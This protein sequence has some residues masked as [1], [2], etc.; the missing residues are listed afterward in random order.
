M[1]GTTKPTPTQKSTNSTPV[2]GNAKNTASISSKTKKGY[3]KKA[4]ELIKKLQESAEKLGEA[5]VEWEKEGAE[6][7]SMAKSRLMQLEPFFAMLLFKL[8]AYPCYAIPTVSTDGSVILYNPQF[9]H[10]HMLRKDVLFTLLHEIEHVFLKHNTRGPIKGVDA[11][12]IMKRY[13]KSKESGVKD[14]FMDDHIEEMKHVL[15]EWNKAADY[16]INDHIFN[17]TN[18]QPTKKFK[19]KLLYNKQYTDKTSEY[20]YK[21]IKTKRDPKKQEEFDV[22]IGGILPVGFGGED[23]S[24][25]EVAAFE[26]EFEGE[27]KAAALSARRAGKLP[28]GIE[29]TIEDLYTTTTPWQDIFR[30]IFTS[31][32]K[33]DYTFAYPNKRY[34]QHMLD[35]GVI[36]PSLYGEEY[37]NCG[38]IMDTSGSVGPREKAILV[39]ELK[40]I[41]EDYPIKLHVL[42]CDSKAYTND[43][44][45]LTQADI[46]A[47]K[48]KLNVK[49]GGGTDMRPAFDY[50]R[51]NQDELQFETVICLTDMYLFNW[52]LGSEPPFST[53]WARL[54]QADKNVKPPFGSCIDIEVDGGDYNDYD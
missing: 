38:F 32:N 20:V 25:A 24:E 51:D 31:I 54:P 49:G 2:K 6:K 5:K 11:K 39:S 8:P 45:I 46:K 41:L 26:K 21:K 33:Q 12:A 48:L 27:V 13:L 23:M 1:S 35:Y 28:A 47:G 7:I 30:T 29:K 3:K 40:C 10:E 37:V 18:I 22:G 4:R 17:N 53:Y 44:E 43:V 14:V 42:Y 19:E 34:T 15:S 36:M 50:F 16:V 52:N 9:V